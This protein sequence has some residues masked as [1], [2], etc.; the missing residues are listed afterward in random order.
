VV[1]SICYLPLNAAFI[2]HTFK[3]K[4]QSLPNTEY[5]IYLSVILSCIQ[6][7]FEKEGRDH[8]LP[9]KL[10]SLGDL[11]RNEAVREPFHCLCELA[12]HGV[13]DNKMTF[14]SN[15]LPQG[16]NTLSLLQAIESFLESGKSV[17][18]NFLHLSIQEILTGYHITFLSDSQ[19]VSQ[20]QKLFNQP[21][22]TAVL[23]FFA[24]ITKLENPGIRQVIARIVES[25]SK[26][27]LLS[28]LRCLH[29]AQDPSLCSY[30]ADSLNY[31][32][33]LAYSSLSPLDC[34]CISYFLLSVADTK[35]ITVDLTRCYIDHL[36]AKCLTKYLCNDTDNVSRLT[37]NLEHN[38]INKESASQIAR[39]FYVAEHL[40]LSYNQIGD[41]GAI[42]ISEAVR[43]TVALK[44][45]I[46]YKCGI[47]SSGAEDLSRAVAHN[48]SLEKLDIGD[49]NL[50]DGG[51]NHLAE[52]LKQNTHLKE[53]WIAYCGMTDKGAASLASA[54]TVNSSLKILHMG[55]LLKGAVTEDGLSTITQSLVYNP[56]FVKLVVGPHFEYTAGCLRWKI[57]ET[58]EGN[59]F[60]PIE[61][62]GKLYVR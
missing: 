42:F 62:E 48:S 50:G 20:F 24:A 35:D 13:M 46:L 58:R 25:K 61:I 27:L 39:L 31:E 7:H 18:Y 56:E 44:T 1:Q 54:L 22:F 55:G 41:T 5:E 15:D 17:F 53:L 6:R 36:C 14:S 51:I 28:L 11:S 19:Q 34:L 59:K 10:T 2:V 40:Y 43:E 52:A 12:H 57:N 60:S 49:N 32:L 23:Q 21:R 8:D 33:Y 26:P 3:Y 37:M 38:E 47:T 29:E 16:S 9:R 4:G 30:V 45:L